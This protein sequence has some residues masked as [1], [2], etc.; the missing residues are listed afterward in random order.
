MTAVQVHIIDDDAA[1]REAL[2]FLLS[3]DDLTATAYEAAE[4]FLA[5]AT[6]AAGCVVTDVRMP[7]MD[8]LE[9]AKRLHAMGA[10][11]PVIMITGNADL[12]LAVEAMR[13]GVADFIEKP[14]DDAIMLAA[15]RRALTKGADVIGAD[16]EKAELLGRLST[17]SPREEQVMQG[18]ATGKSN[19]AIAR[20]LEISPQM[21]EVYR[22]HLM[23]KVGAGSLSEL[24]R[25]ALRTGVI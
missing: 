18:L 23:T 15:V 25:I 9:L 1:V 4:P 5:I 6:E 8:G 12:A 7:D 10:D 21:V 17:L 13:A 3:T 19:K 16:L 20:E 11:L 24:V 2:V 22:A 14:F